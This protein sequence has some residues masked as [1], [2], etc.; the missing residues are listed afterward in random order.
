[1]SIVVCLTGLPRCGKNTLAKF[2][3]EHPSFD[4]AEHAVADPLYE[5]VSESFSVS[6][7][8]LKSHEWKTTPQNILASWRSDD[9]D[10]RDLCRKMGIDMVE[11]KTSRFHLRTW[12]TEYRRMRDAEY[13]VNKLTPRLAA[14]E[15]E[16]IV[17][18][19]FRAFD[20]AQTEYTHLRQ[21]AATTGRK[22]ALIEVLADW[23]EAAAH[24]S[25]DRFPE[26]MIDMTVRNVYDN[27]RVMARA[28]EE[29]I[30][31]TLGE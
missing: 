29:F 10:Y 16:D 28:V 7:E 20:K 3:A 22:F 24:S 9:P 5:E 4:F 19:D 12:G 23:S 15:R 17:I 13:W 25:D 21:F 26:H 14:E 1:M 31:E 6:V 8:D 11:P 2:L 27:P 18:N 30:I